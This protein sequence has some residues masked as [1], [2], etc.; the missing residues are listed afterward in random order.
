MT[1]PTKL[2]SDIIGKQDIDLLIEWLKD[3][4]RLTKGEK[5]LEFEDGFSKKINS[6]HSIYCNSGSSANLLIVSALQ[7][8]GL[9]HNNK[10]VVPQVSWSTTVFPVIQFGLTPVLCD[11]NLDNLGI[12]VVHLEQIIRDEKPAAIILVHVLGFDSHIEKIIELC[13]ANNVIV[14]EDTCES[15]GSRTSGKTLG[16]FGLASSFSFYFGHHISTIEGGMVCTNDDDFAD[17]IRMIRSHGWDRDLSDEKKQ[18]YRS[19]CEATDFDSLYK[20]YYAGFNLRS[21]DLQAFLGINQLSKI[22]FITEQREANYWTYRNNLRDDLWKPTLEKNQDTVSNMGYPIIVKN[23]NEIYNALSKEQIE[24]RPLVAGSMG[25]QPA[26]VNLYGEA[27]MP[28]ATVIDK[29]GMYLP[30]HQDLTEENI[31]NICSIINK[32]AQQCRK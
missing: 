26:W 21:T 29:Q 5:T 8:M 10:V 3:V 30:N 20:F 28:N 18:Q 17:M 9:L 7:Q 13:E 27:A 19:A 24:C 25:M 4:P 15:L 14:I 23:K 11:C 22:D 1:M 32:E 12:D 6:K 2:C 16:T 31:I